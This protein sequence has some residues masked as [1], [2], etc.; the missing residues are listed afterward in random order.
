MSMTVSVR[1]KPMK[2]GAISGQVSH[3]F[4]HGHQPG[5]VDSSRTHLNSSSCDVPTVPSDLI[6]H[7]RKKCKSKPRSDWSPAW[8]GIITWGT[9][10]QRV[11][12]ALPTVEQDALYQQIAQ[13]IADQL[14][15]DVH[16][17]AV[18][19]DESA[20]HAH[21][22]ICGISNITG[23]S[24][25]PK[26]ADMKRLQDLAGGC[27]AHLNITRGIEKTVR[28]ERGE[29]YSKTINRSVKQLH[30]DLPREIQAL[31]KTRDNLAALFKKL[32]KAPRLEPVEIITKRRALMPPVT[33]IQKVITDAQRR[34]WF[35]YSKSRFAE[36]FAARESEINAMREE[37]ISTRYKITEKMR[38][39]EAI[40]EKMQKQALWLKREL[41]HES[42]LSQARNIRD[43]ALTIITPSR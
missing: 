6:E 27:C 38:E 15:V 36:Y 21:F 9:D 7:A 14:G 2:S 29:D 10:A 30:Q 32:P 40:A 42:E 4:R 18:H 41:S 5:Y 39:I 31:E 25:R 1:I 3:D 28:I 16:H 35:E 8:S 22:M 17:V 34:E 19:R 12:Q 20:P 37:V 23:K 13:R 43:E 26:P 11:I 24:I 33:E